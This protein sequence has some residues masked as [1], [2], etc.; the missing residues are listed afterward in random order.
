MDETS[1]A[2]DIYLIRHTRTNIPETICCGVSDVEL[3]ASYPDELESIERKTEGLRQS[4]VVFSSPLKRCSQLAGD[5]SNGKVFTDERIKELDF[6]NWELRPWSVLSGLAFE[7]WTADFVTT[8]CPGGESFEDLSRRSNSFFKELT[9]QQC[10]QVMVI[11]HAGVIRSIL[12]N[13][14]HVPLSRSFGMAI[15]PGG[16]TGIRL[17]KGCAATVLFVNR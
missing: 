11:T 2:M 12:S 4:P 15:E 10:E 9:A 13:V 1:A 17:Q 6:G 7:R 5:L 14:L 16:I 8:R 3:A